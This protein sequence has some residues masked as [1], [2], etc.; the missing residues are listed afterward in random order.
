MISCKWLIAEEFSFSEKNTTLEIFFYS[1]IA[2]TMY[3]FWGEFTP[4]GLV[5]CSIYF[6][7]LFIFFTYRFYI[8]VLT[9]YLYFSFGLLAVFFPLPILFKNLSA[10]DFSGDSLL[11]QVFNAFK[12]IH[13]FNYDSNYI[14]AIFL[15]LFIYTPSILCF[16]F[17]LF[18][19]S[20]ANIAVAVLIYFINIKRFFVWQTYLLSAF[21]C[22]F[23]YT[24]S[25]DLGI[26]LAQKKQ[27]IES[28][29]Y[30]IS[31]FD[32]DLFFF[33]NHL[34]P[35]NTKTVGHTI[36]GSI[37]K[38]GILY[39]IVVF[40][41]YKKICQY[42]TL[43]TSKVVYSLFLL[44]LV[45]LSLFIFVLPLVFSLSEINKNYKTRKFVSGFF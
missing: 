11:W 38:D 43:K 22:W 32:L 15:V 9:K 36:Y 4:K 19:V 24:Y 20:R 10:I 8:F 16:F 45:S 41:C 39:W 1:I 37:A 2:A 35:T 5:I 29:N 25:T 26:A 21:L 40:L 12:Y 7:L 6:L 18:T 33:G 34:K 42:K 28:F 31:N 3:F 13:F 30:F 27:T 44:S 17:I 23:F 14:G